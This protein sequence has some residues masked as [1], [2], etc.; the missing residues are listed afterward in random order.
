MRRGRSTGNPTKEE[1]ARIVA[2]KEGPCMACLVRATRGL[3]DWDRIV[4]GCDYHHT[5]SG[6]I[7]RGHMFG[8]ALCLW[9]HHGTQQLHGLGMSAEAARRRYGPSL[10]DQSKAFH[11]EFGSDDE[12]ITLQT[13]YIETGYG[14]L[15]AA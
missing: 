12:L 11:Q 15:Q 6:N 2:A 14:H 8:F 1:A 10:F 4:H 9:H 3:L 13:K 5:K 7:R